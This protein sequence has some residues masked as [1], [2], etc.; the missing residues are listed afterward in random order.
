MLHGSCERTPLAESCRT[1]E[2][3]RERPQPRDSA[4][5]ESAYWA[6]QLKQAPHCLRSFRLGDST[7]K[8]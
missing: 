5:S 2:H 3:E 6:I 1:M 7:L 8:V 4:S